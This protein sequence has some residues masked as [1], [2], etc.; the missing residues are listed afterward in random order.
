MKRLNLDIAT[1]R[2]LNYCANGT[3]GRLCKIHGSLNWLYCEKCKRLDLFVSPRSGTQDGGPIRTA[4]ALEDLYH[5]VPFGEAYSCQGTPCRRD[6][7]DGSVSPILITPTFVKDYENPHV[8]KVWKAA[9]HAM[10]DATRA[11]IVGYSLPTDDVDVAMLFKRGLD[12]LDR[13]RITVVEHVG[14]DIDKPQAS[15]TPMEAHEVGRR[16]RTVLGSGVDWH[17]TGFEGWLDEQGE[18]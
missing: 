11:V 5:S 16:Y 3:Y 9:E 14:N 8:D 17:T 4:K 1:E 15:R 12:H 13:A 6:T 18:F 10:K 2:Y 7:C